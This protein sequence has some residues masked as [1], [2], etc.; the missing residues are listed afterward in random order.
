MH[1][2]GHLAETDVAA[3]AAIDP[4][5]ASRVV[6]E[7]VQPDPSMDLLLTEVF[8]FLRTGPVPVTSM[9]AVNRGFELIIELKSETHACE[10]ADAIAQRF[11]NDPVYVVVWPPAR[12]ADDGVPFFGLW[13]LSEGAPPQVDRL[14]LELKADGTF[15]MRDRC[16][17]RTGRWRV[18]HDAVKTITFIDVAV[19]AM[20]C[21]TRPDILE[22]PR[23]ARIDTRGEL[24]VEQ[25]TG[26]ALA[27]TR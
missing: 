18:D 15:T 2:T 8:E 10:V 11:P 23:T 17:Y 12:L 3:R 4:K 22:S 27:Y 13:W 25:I 21:A 26:K 24:L 9:S 16:N 14:Q 20:A 5:F 7:F 6:V 19:T 1:V